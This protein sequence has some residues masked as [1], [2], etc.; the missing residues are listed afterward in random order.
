M[1]KEYQG[2]VSELFLHR[3]G[4][5]TLSLKWDTLIEAEE[6]VRTIESLMRELRLL[7]RELRSHTQEN[8]S[9]IVASL[10]GSVQEL[11]AII[12]EL[13]LARV[14]IGKRKHEKGSLEVSYGHN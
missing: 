5:T 2:R 1:L 9:H 4:Q 10:D 14:Q 3:F 12:M 6:H 11:D 7:K 13:A 8:S